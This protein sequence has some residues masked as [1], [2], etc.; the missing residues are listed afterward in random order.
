MRLTPLITSS[1]IRQASGESF[2]FSDL[3]AKSEISPM[4][5]MT[6]MPKMICPVAISAAVDYHIADARRRADQLG[7]NDIGPCPAEDETEN[8]RNIGRIG[9]NENAADHAPVFAPSV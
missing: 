4:T 9:G 8:F 2:R 1:L 7:N 3:N 6:M 5:P